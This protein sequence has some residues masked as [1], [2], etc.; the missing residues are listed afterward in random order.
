MPVPPH[1]PVMPVP[2]R[3]AKPV[4]HSIRAETKHGTDEP[5]RLPGHP[6]GGTVGS[7]LPGR[8][9]QHRDTSYVV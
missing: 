2:A 8:V 5:R 1:R 7:V 3:S 9:R 4:N 6:G